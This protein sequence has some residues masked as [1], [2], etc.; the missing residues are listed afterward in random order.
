[1]NNNNKPMIYDCFMFFNELDLL[2]IRLNI[3]KNV[4]DKFIIS[5][6]NRTF[7]NIP[8]DLTL[9][10]N[11][12]R[13][14]DFHHKIEYIITDE[15]NLPVFESA[16]QFENFQRDIMAESLK[17]CSDNDIIIISDLDEIPNPSKI[18]EYNDKEGIK[19]FDLK[20]YNFYLNYLTKEVPWKRGPKLF[21]YKDLKDTTLTKIRLGEGEHISGCG[22][23]F[24]YLGGIEKVVYKIKSAAHQEYNTPYHMDLKRITSI[25]SRGDDL[26]ERGYKFSTV[27]LD[28][29]F[30]E[31]IVKNQKKYENLIL[32]KQSRLNR[33][34][35]KL[36]N[37]INRKIE[38]CEAHNTLYDFVSYSFN[39]VHYIGNKDNT[40]LNKHFEVIKLLPEEIDRIKNNSI[41]CLVIEDCFEKI[42]IREILNKIKIKMTPNG[43]IVANAKNKRID[44]K[45]TRK[46]IKAIITDEKYYFVAFKGK[47]ARNSILFKI[48]DFFTAFS[49]YDQKY[50]EYIFVAK[51]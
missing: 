42:N 38:P 12:E 15:N 5:E 51:S 40:G 30:P 41:N 50:E 22:W 21:F 8:K 7:S 37:Y 13:F 33:L 2:E 6:S 34:K 1:M 9:K 44:G 47:K 31:Y 45:Y 49:L 23:H 3:L 27:K 43:Y 4:V 24:S 35:A 29:T 48:A 20:H 28:N 26:F 39:R 25:I 14:K 11:W 17:G 16:W 10:Q 19:A 18:I 32:K 46:G 36:T